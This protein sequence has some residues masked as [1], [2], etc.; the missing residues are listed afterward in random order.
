MKLD[1][2]IVQENG[3]VEITLTGDPNGD[4]F[5]ASRAEANELMKKTGCK[6]LLVDATGLTRMLPVIAD[7]EFTT[8]HT[9]ELPKGTRHAVIVNPVH[10]ERM[11]FVEDVA[12]NRFIDLRIFTDRAKALSWLID[13]A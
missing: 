8:G 5:N 12:Q 7:F 2:S 3:Y 9:T 1:I 10:M 13:K 11:Q 6:G 4:R